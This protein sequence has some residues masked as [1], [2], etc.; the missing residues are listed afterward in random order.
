MPRRRALA[1]QP[2]LAFF[3]QLGDA[4][5]QTFRFTVGA[6]VD[7]ARLHPAGGGVLAHH[8]GHHLGDPLAQLALIAPAEGQG[9]V[10]QQPG[11]IIAAHLPFAAV[12]AGLRGQIER[13]IMDK[14]D[15]R[16]ALGGGENVFTVGIAE[17]QR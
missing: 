15:D 3:L 2:F 10:L 16:L 14:G 5:A 6:F 9:F 17:P 11:E 4:A 8:V 1:A 7:A 13:L 12:L